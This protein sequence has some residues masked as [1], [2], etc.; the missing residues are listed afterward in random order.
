M[1]HV[2]IEVHGGCVVEVSV[3]E[4]NGNPVEF[5]STIID[6]D[7]EEIEEGYEGDKEDNDTNDTEE[8]GE[9]KS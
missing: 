4:D 2:E 8:Y 6:H 1:L 5:D 3:T 9:E 7:V